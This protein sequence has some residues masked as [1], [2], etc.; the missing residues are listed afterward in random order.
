MIP[1]ANK[2]AAVTIVGGLQNH[3]LAPPH[4]EMDEHSQIGKDILQAMHDQDPRKLV[5]ALFALMDEYESH[6]HHEGP[7]IEEE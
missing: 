7:H 3:P 4:D 5:E 2:K 1:F 6:P